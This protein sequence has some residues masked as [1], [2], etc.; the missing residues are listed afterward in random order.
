MLFKE[1]KIY[2]KNRPSL[3]KKLAPLEKIRPLPKVFLKLN[4]PNHQIEKKIILKR[5]N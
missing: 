5:F 4:T 2:K 1:P 3:L